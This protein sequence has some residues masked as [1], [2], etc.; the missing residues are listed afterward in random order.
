MRD[1]ILSKA[2][3]ISLRDLRNCTSD[4]GIVAGAHHFVDLW[5]RD[6]LFASFGAL[7]GGEDGAAKKTIETFLSYQRK[8]GLV[9]YRV[10]RSPTTIGKYFGHPTYLKKPISNFRSHQSGGIVPDGGL[11]TVIASQLYV[12]QTNDSAFL[13]AHFLHLTR[14]MDWYGLRFHGGLIREWFLCEWADAVLKAGYTLYTNILYW[15]ALQC[16]SMLAKKQGDNQL[17]LFYTYQKEKIAGCIRNTF[18]NKTY[19]TDWVDYKKQAYLSSHANLLAI[20]FGFASR[21]ERTLLLKEISNRND[22][23]WAIETNDPSYPWWRIPL[24]NYCVGMGDYHNRGCI[25][26][27]PSILYAIALDMAG[28]KKEAVKRLEMLAQKIIAYD[29]V[30]EVYDRSGRPLKRLLYRAEGPFAWSAGLYLVAYQS[31]VRGHPDIL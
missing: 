18:W 13:D 16:M 1:S 20:V 31:I 4:V 11:M 7:V 27:Q 30:Y 9:P 5:A 12:S 28:R 21:G 3:D 26:L 14:A 8:D 15:K 25:W 24:W 17:S 10:L 6:S 22:I 19:F 23:G 29:G 2:Y